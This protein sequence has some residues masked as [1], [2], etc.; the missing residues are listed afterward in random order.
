MRVGGVDL[1]TFSLDG[2]L[3]YLNNIFQFDRQG[4]LA[5]DEDRACMAKTYHFKL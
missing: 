3:I 4:R 5:N 2:I 1:L